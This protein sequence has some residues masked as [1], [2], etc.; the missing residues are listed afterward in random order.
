MK[1]VSGIIA[2]RSF[3]TLGEQS[4]SFIHPEVCRSSFG[5]F[6]CTSE[7]PLGFLCVPHVTSCTDGTSTDASKLK[8]VR[9]IHTKLMAVK[10]SW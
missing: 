4:I 10:I 9:A 6:I 7:V 8:P 5:F 1:W 3:L 2:Q